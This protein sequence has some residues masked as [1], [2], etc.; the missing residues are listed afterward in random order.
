MNHDQDT[1][2]TRYLW[3]ERKLS[4][5]GHDIASHR[6]HHHAISQLWNCNLKS[7]TDRT[8]TSTSTIHHNRHDCPFVLIFPTIIS[9]SVFVVTVVSVSSKAVY[10]TTR[11]QNPLSYWSQVHDYLSLQ[12]RRLCFHWYFFTVIV[13]GFIMTR[14]VVESLFFSFW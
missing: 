7:T 8:T 14:V 11:I 12:R 9:A 10:V 4:H 13:F 6:R 2:D 5:Y 1:E 3:L